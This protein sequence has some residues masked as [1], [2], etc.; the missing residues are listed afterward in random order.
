MNSIASK[1]S[2]WIMESTESRSLKK[3]RIIFAMIWLC[4]DVLS[5]AFGEMDHFVWSLQNPAHG[6]LAVCQGLLIIT[7]IGLLLGWRAR[8][9]AFLC[10]GLRYWETTVVPLNDFYYYCSTALI[11]SVCGIANDDGPEVAKW[12]KDV[13]ILQTVWIYFATALLKL[14]SLWLSGGDLD[15]RFRYQRLMTS[16][17]LNAAL[18]IATVVIEFT[19]ALLLFSL[20]KNPEKGGRRLRQFL[21]L[22]VIGVHVFAAFAL[23]V[24]FFG[25]SMIAQVFVIGWSI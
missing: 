23:N 2:A 9:F 14:N 16:Q 10:F 25:A 3:F 21:L 20:W 15:V 11:L 24:W 18:A 6:E 22:L 13:L 19:I 12:P 5:L 7:E 4:Y 1:F 17:S 8:T